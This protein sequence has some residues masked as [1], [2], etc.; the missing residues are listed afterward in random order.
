MANI[1]LN[2]APYFDDFDGQKGFHRILFKPGYAV[3]ARELTQLQTILQEQIKRFGDHV[4]KDGS[5]IFGCAESSNFSMPYVKINDTTNV[6]SVISNDSLSSYEGA[7][8]TNAAGVTAVIKKTLPGSETDSIKKTLFVQYTSASTNSLTTE[9]VEGDVL[10]VV[11]EGINT[12]FEVY[13]GVGGGIGEGSLFSVGDGVV[14]SNG[15][16]VLHKEQTIVLEPYTTTPSQKV[17]FIVKEALVSS[18]TDKTL[19][20][21]AR[22]SYNYTAPG[23]DRYQLETQLV[24]YPLGTETDEGFYVLFEVE[25]GL[26]KRK[27][28]QT[29]YGELNRTLARRTYDESGDYTVRTFP[30]IVREHLL[31]NENGGRFES[32]DAS[33]LSVA[34]EPGKAYVRGY[35][36]ELFAAEYLT[37]PK[38]TATQIFENQSLT[39]AIGNF[40]YVENVVG[41][42]PINTYATVNL[43][44]GTGASTVIGTARVR[45]FDYYSGSTFKLYLYDISMNTG[46]SFA[47]VLSIGTGVSQYA[48]I[49]R[50]PGETTTILRQ[51]SLT[52]AVFEASQEFVKQVSDA[53]YVYRRVVSGVSFTSGAGAVSAAVGESWAFTTANIVNELSNDVIVINESSG[54]VLNLTSASVSAGSLNITLATTFSGTATVLALSK[55]TTASHNTKTLRK[56]G[57]VRIEVG[58]SPS[59]QTFSLG[60][61]DVLEVSEIWEASSAQSWV[62]DPVSDANWTNVTSNFIVDNG[63]R[64]TKYELGSIT[65]NTAISNKK[66]IVKLTYLEHAT[67]SPYYTV[68]SYP[69]P[70]EGVAPTASQIDWH[71]IPTYRASS[72]RV[73][74]LRNCID[75][76]F[77]LQNTASY[78]TTVLGSTVTPAAGSA[79]PSGT[80]THSSPT[81][82]FDYDLTVHLPRIDSVVLDSEGK[83]TIY[84]GAPAL[85]P[86]RQRQPDNSMVLGYINVAP[87]PSLSPYF[88]RVT[89]KPQYACNITMTDNRRFTMRDIGGFN[90]RISRIEYYTALSLLEQ[91]TS[92]LIITNN[93]TGED[94]FKNG[95]LVDAFN[96][97][98]IGNVYDSKYNCS[99]ANGQLRPAFNLENIDF[100][101]VTPNTSNIQITGNLATLKYTHKVF[102]ENP[103][104]S[105]TRNAVSQLLF[106]YDG[107]L[108]LNPSSD[109]W[110]DVTTRPELQI[111]LEGGADNWEAIAN[112]WGTQWGNWETLWQGVDTQSGPV[113]SSTVQ[114]IT[115]TTTQRQ[116]RVGTGITVT[117]NTVTNNLG[118]RV[119]SSALIPFMR[120]R[121]VNFSGTRMK[122]NTRV[123]AYFD[124][125]NVS[126]HCKLSSSETYG[127]P[128]IVGADG[129]IS[130]Q[131]LIPAETFTV[132]TKVFTLCDDAVN[133][134]SSGIKTIGS[135]NFTASGLSV[136]QQGT[137][138]ST[139][140][141]EVTVNRQTETR[142]VV[143]TRTVTLPTVTS[144]DP[145]AQT[146]FVANNPGGIM[147][148]KI[149][150]YF[151][152]KSTTAGITLQ[153]REVVNGYPGSTIVPYGTATLAPASVSVS[154][155]ASVATTFTFASP[156]YLQNDTEYCFVLLPAG[157]DENYEVWVSE[158]GQN[159]IGTTERIDKQPYA[160]VLFVS[161]NNRTW[162]AIQSEDITFTL[163]QCQFDTST[164]GVIEFVNKQIDYLVL[165]DVSDF[166]EGDVV[167]FV[168]GSVQSDTGTISFIDTVNNIAKVN[169]S[170]GAV[171]LSDFMVTKGTVLSG[172]ATTVGVLT[173]SQ[174]TDD[175]WGTGSN[176][177]STVSPGDII[178]TSTGAL[179]GEVASVTSDDAFVLTA[180]A[181]TVITN[182]IINV[183]KKAEV[184]GFEDKIVNAISPTLGFL[185][186]NNTD[187]DWQYKIAN[188]GGSVGAYNNMSGAGTL[189]LPVEYRVFSAS[190]YTDTFFLKS[191]ISSDVA[192]ISPVIDLSR[193]GCVVIEND[194]NAISTNEENSDLDAPGQ[195][196]SKY[197]S[198]RVVLDDGQEAEDLR[199]YLTADIQTG[200]EVKVYA[201]LLNDT[202]STTFDNRPWTLMTQTTPPSTVGYRDYIFDLPTDTGTDTLGEFGAKDS[203]SGVYT[204]NTSFTGFKTFAVKIVLL[205][206]STAIVPKIR[207][208]R[209][210]ALQV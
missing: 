121:V 102:A 191:T 86:V 177:L 144:P 209:A 14:Y 117:T 210:I 1:N 185:D 182:G 22:G 113:D 71:E 96:N 76:R 166:V 190:N 68:N 147:L 159:Q 88:A 201:K 107:T 174:D 125:I 49:D 90:S 207:D 187:I 126:Q 36:H 198:R 153:I 178:L 114:Q 43:Y 46:E 67:N 127:T 134:R 110:T 132:G 33:L 175:V 47:N 179:I 176:Y 165:S 108:S 72:G 100:D 89:G 186:F 129:T 136:V 70:V 155:D 131:F 103:Y 163:Y 27:F 192:N 82:E 193:I 195:A 141:P 149:D 152:T 208:M 75:F 116:E 189:E 200:A 87:Y 91:N 122:P 105:K 24:T 39:T 34:I 133:P 158:L 60:V 25:N 151:K 146:F 164:A 16:F 161:A 28:N 23:A 93:S 4:F 112:A 139:Q 104:S 162:T 167:S 85:N 206:S 26:I 92:N 135:T 18:N 119:V 74:D 35:E 63:Q 48:N 202:D 157:N 140:V 138:I 31:E 120:R 111:N 8:L 32:G 53:S 80:I 59:S 171:G 204:Y 196:R 30:I 42:M 10:S 115:E 21:P 169:V 128:L 58:A 118:N 50:L 148:S 54:A 62:S 98:S 168:N 183:A 137:V 95:I 205:S 29:Q 97:H 20:D 17:G 3:Q 52:P 123:Y 84:Q 170:T 64:D 160:G 197:I 11:G 37:T 203:V 15:F 106:T 142:D 5:V 145:I 57:Y 172:T 55:N 40:V 41:V 184:N 12:T 61:H 194:V 94:R 173:G 199:V 188:T 2:T 69:L 65:A 6:G 181:A 130:G 99:I 44:S 156:V 19:L 56:D 13:S 109:V 73:Y 150:V 77:A 78:S 81:E 66:L 154:D 7:I 38:S 101:M 83:F 51:A 45:G 124:N 143:V 9:F 180:P 79:V